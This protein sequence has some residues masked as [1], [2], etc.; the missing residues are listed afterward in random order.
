M[1]KDIYIFVFLK[2]KNT[3]IR[4]YFGVLKGSEVLDEI[5]RSLKTRKS[6]RFRM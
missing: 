3:N 6:A 2:R 1:A 5:E 4:K